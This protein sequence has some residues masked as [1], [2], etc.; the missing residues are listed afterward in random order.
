MRIT[1]PKYG[2]REVP[3]SMADV[4]T[5]TGWSVADDTPPKAAKKKPARRRRKP[6]DD[7]GTAS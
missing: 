2:S 3:A 1:H 7:E 4:W 5:R 6:A